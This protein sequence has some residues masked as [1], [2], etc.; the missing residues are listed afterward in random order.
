[1]SF[2]I[3]VVVLCLPQASDMINAILEGYP[4]S[5]KEF[6]VSKKE[7]SLPAPHLNLWVNSLKRFPLHRMRS[8]WRRTR[9]VRQFFRALERTEDD[10]FVQLFSSFADE[11]HRQ[12]YWLNCEVL[13]SFWAT[14]HL[15]F[16]AFH[17]SRQYVFGERNIN[18]KYSFL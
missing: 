6:L 11:E 1:M 15:F 14:V 13:S 12:H 2:I 7:P 8:E 4:R 5:K 3:T 18:C 10:T 9:T 16:I 17:L